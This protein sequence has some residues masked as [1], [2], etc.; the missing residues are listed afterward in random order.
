M[1]TLIIAALLLISSQMSFAQYFQKPQ[2]EVG[3]GY[4]FKHQ[5]GFGIPRVTVA[6]ND[7]FN[8]DGR[9]LIGAYATLEYRSGI[10]FKEDGTNYYFRM[11]VGLNFALPRLPEFQIFGGAD[12]LSYAMGKN[13]RKE[14]GMRYAFNGLY[15]VRAGYSNWVGFTLGA[16]YQFPVNRSDES[17][18]ASSG[19]RIGGKKAKSDLTPKADTIVK[20]VIKEV[21]VEVIREV[22][23]TDTVEV[24]EKVFETDTVKRNMAPKYELLATFYFELNSADM[25]AESASRYS[26]ELRALRLRYPNEDLLVVG[27][28]D[29][30]GNNAF[31]Y[32]LGI[33]RAQKIANF[34]LSE[35]GLSESK[36]TVRSDG[37][38]RPQSANAD[39]N[40]RVDIY[41]LKFE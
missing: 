10:T 37:K 36:M 21:P 35:T 6:A 26:Q 11:P 31:N 17:F 34:L 41:I 14:I 9:G 15:S 20:E 29:S 8:G 39:E 33:G 19:K 12:V 5:E 30:T 1:R 22:R 32:N 16:G 2:Y 38:I 23:V 7:F 13:L 18:N 25:T 24:M 4:A 27:N 3:V 40:R 28:T